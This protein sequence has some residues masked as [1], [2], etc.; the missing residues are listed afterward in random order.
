MV[1]TMDLGLVVNSKGTHEISS[2]YLPGYNQVKNMIL[3]KKSRGEYFDKI[4]TPE[5][6]FYVHHFYC[7]LRI[8]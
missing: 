3:T 7:F 5:K 4:F 6:K 1:G 8:V 2:T